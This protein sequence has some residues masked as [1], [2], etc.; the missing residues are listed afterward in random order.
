MKPP[1]KKPRLVSQ[2][3]ARIHRNL[4]GRQ[5]ASPGRRAFAI[6]VDMILVFIL[7]AFAVSVSLNRRAPGLAQGIIRMLSS[8]ESDPSYSDRSLSLMTSVFAFV[9][10]YRPEMLPDSIRAALESND[11]AF[12]RRLDIK[13]GLTLTMDI[14][15][16]KPSTYDPETGLLVLRNDL[17]FGKKPPFLEGFTFFLLYFTFTTWV[18]AGKTP[19]KALARI[20]VARL[21]LKRL[22]LWDAFGRAGGYSAS[23]STGCL[24]FLEAIWHPNRQTIHDRIAGT[25]VLKETREKKSGN[26]APQA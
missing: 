24:G 1:R 15:T 19:G 5:L 21:D 16:G 3:P 23:L 20:R 10:R 12:F 13:P 4:I 8:Q 2:E 25:V 7:T 22:N 9:N 6:A 17:L 26:P 14:S 11:T 18:M